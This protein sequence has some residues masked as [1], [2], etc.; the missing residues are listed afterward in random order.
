MSNEKKGQD[1]RLK[2]YTSSAAIRYI[3]TVGV[4]KRT[5]E[6]RV[7]V[8]AGSAVKLDSKEGADLIETLGRVVFARHPQQ[9]NITDDTNGKLISSIA[10]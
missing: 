4:P 5:G 3:K 8:A 1:A 7:M 10:V 2:F 6:F 9:I